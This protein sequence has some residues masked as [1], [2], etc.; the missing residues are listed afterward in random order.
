MS[1]ARCRRF[2]GSRHASTAITAP[3]ARLETMVKSM[4]GT[5]RS[6]R[7]AAR[8]RKAPRLA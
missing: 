4:M 8:R 7:R 6:G 1:V 2:A 5:Y 3:C